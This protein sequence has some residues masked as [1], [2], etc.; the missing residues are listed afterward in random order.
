[1]LHAGSDSILTPDIVVVTF[2]AFNISCTHN[3]SQI[4]VFAKGFEQTR[5]QRLPPNPERRV[6][7]PRN[8]RGAHFISCDFGSLFHKFRIPGR[9]HPET[10]W[11]NCRTGRIIGT[12]NGINPVDDRNAET[13]LFGGHVLNLG[14]DVVPVLQ[15]VSCTHYIEN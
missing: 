6:E 5:P 1:M 13:T 7:V 11:E 10:L 9:G 8:S 3:R 12:M 2:L 15:G 14:D 4:G